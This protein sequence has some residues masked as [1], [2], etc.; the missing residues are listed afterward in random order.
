MCVPYISFSSRISC[1]SLSFSSLLLSVRCD[2]TYTLLSLIA[3]YNSWHLW[4]NQAIPPIGF[5]YGTT[6]FPA[7]YGDLAHLCMTVVRKQRG[8]S[9]ALC[10][11]ARLNFQTLDYSIAWV[12]IVCAADTTYGLLAYICLTEKNSSSVPMLCVSRS[13]CSY[14][15]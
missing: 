2:C 8:F 14:N 13:R 4:G 10:V 6:S 5:A 11:S 12:L 7:P 3:V 15:T 9:Y 1:L